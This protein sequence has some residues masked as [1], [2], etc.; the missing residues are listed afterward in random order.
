MPMRIFSRACRPLLLLA[1]VVGTSRAEAIDEA[2]T[3]GQSFAAQVK[4]FLRQNCQGCHELLLLEDDLTEMPPPDDEALAAATMGDLRSRL[5]AE[6]A[7]LIEDPRSSRFFNEFPS[8]WPSLEKFSAVEPDRSRFPKLTHH[9]R[10]HLQQELVR[11]LEYI[12]RRNLPIRNLIDSDFIVANEVTADY[13]D[14][15]DHTESDSI[16]GQV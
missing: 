15:A 5:D 14:F 6:V 11:F 10:E 8:Q 2:T 1:L 13:Y 16:F 3:L 12:V 9:A 7:R 4:P